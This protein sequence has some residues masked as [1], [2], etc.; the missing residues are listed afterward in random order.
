MPFAND[1]PEQSEA[2]DLVL[3]VPDFFD[4]CTR[5]TEKPGEMIELSGGGY[6]LP[7]IPDI[8]EVDLESG[9]NTLDF[10]TV[11]SQQSRYLIGTGNQLKWCWPQVVQESGLE[12]LPKSTNLGD[13]V[14]ETHWSLIRRM[15]HQFFDDAGDHPAQIWFHPMAFLNETILETRNYKRR[16]SPQNVAIHEYS[17]REPT[18]LLGHRVWKAFPSLPVAAGLQWNIPGGCAEEDTWI[19]SIP[20]EHFY[21]GKL[22]WE[23]VNWRADRLSPLPRS[24]REQVRI[25][26]YLFGH[27]HLAFLACW[28]DLRNRSTVSQMTSS[29]CTLPISLRAIFLDVYLMK[30]WRLYKDWSGSIGAE[31]LVLAFDRNEGKLAYIKVNDG[32]YRLQTG[33]LLRW[34][35]K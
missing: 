5:L 1:Q 9:T 25:N 31:S 23:W 20:T 28:D 10:D 29:N 3:R 35:S 34:L 2:A 32:P 13:R 33:E 4:R 17:L 8:R 30:L 19:A 27:E 22:D 14:M 18:P 7:G 6:S 26:R 24:A 12:A 16:P 21:K 15:V 11:A